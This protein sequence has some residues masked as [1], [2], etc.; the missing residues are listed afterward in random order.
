[1]AIA[2]LSAATKPIRTK[3]LFDAA[4]AGKSYEDW[5]KAAGGS[6]MPSIAPAQVDDSVADRIGQITAQDSPLMQAARTEGL[7]VANRRGL[8]NSSMAAGASQGAAL[9]YALPIASQDAGQDFQRNQA[10]RAFE[11]GMAGQD[12]AQAWQAGESALNRDLE[13][14][15]QGRDIASREKLTLAQIASTEGLAKAQRELDLVM[16]RNAISAVDQQ[17]IRQIASTE[18]MA[19]AERALQERLQG[20]DITSREGLAK[21]QREL[22]ERMQ[23]AAISA[24]DRQ[25]LRD[26]ASREGMAAAERELQQLM[27]GKDIASREK[28]VGQ[29]IAS[30]EKLTL[31]QIASTEGMAAADRAL[32]DMMQSR[33][34]G[35][36]EKQQIR[37]IKSREGLAAAERELQRQLQQQDIQFQQGERKLD[38]QLQEKLASWNLN[39]ADRNAAAS[40]LTAME[41]MYQNQFSAILA[42][43]AMSAKDRESFLNAAKNLRDKQLNMVEQ[44]YNV[45]LK[46]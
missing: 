31:A 29:D 36:A 13:E 7:K 21:A 2:E 35:A 43:T 9:N 8:L 27:Q 16:Q 46:W 10:A 42:N 1:M 40:M 28:L 19:A 39:S 32:E 14:R 17:Q 33:A 30:R 34:I 44:L 11:Y 20:R 15:L 23:G 6:A 37:D 41:G 26:I 24:A 45:D 5:Q 22:E 4:A 38:R 12:S 25:Q 18:G 3:G